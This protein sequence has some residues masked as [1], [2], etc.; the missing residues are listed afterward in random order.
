MPYQSIN[1]YS[2]RQIKQFSDH[3]DAEVD[4]ALAQAPACFPT[5]RKKNVRRAGCCSI[6]SCPNS[7]LANGRVRQ[8]RY[9]RDGQADRRKSR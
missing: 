9:L 6:K 7:A 2:G 1:P 4:I 8:S 5:W 3:T